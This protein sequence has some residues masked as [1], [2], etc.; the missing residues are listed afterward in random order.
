[1]THGPD[2]GLF[3]PPAV[4]PIQ[5][6]IVPVQ[7][8]KEGVLDKANELADKLKAAGIRV[9]VDDSDNSPGWKFAEYEMKG[10]PLRVE[11]GPKDMEKGQCCIC[12]RDTGEKTFVPLDQLEEDV[13][14]LL[15]EVHKGLYNR[16]RKNLEDHTRVCLT[17]EEVKE[18]MASRG[19]FAKTMWCG[20]LEC[21][22]KM[23][24]QAGVTSRCMPLEQEKVGETCVCCGK[25]AK[26]MVYWG[27]AY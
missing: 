24:E 16:A 21:E 14:W 1:M 8:F 19:G 3:L 27:K 17:L 26:Q 11:I 20:D 12:R 5:A 23:K 10:V 18:K 15:D 2:S 6:V 22:L 4:A 25:P 7:Q 9:K 13:R